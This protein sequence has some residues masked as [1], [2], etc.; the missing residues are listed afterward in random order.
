MKNLFKDLYDSFHNNSG[1]F[2]ARKLTGFTIV[3]CIVYTHY[4]HVDASN[5][6]EIHVIDCIFALLL[7]GIITAEQ[8]IKFKDSS[9]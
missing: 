1:G 9:K 5:A 3:M 4:K 8:V 6:V 7:F 2:S